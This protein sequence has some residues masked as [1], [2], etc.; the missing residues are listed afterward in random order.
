MK[1]YFLLLIVFLLC[2]CED[3]RELN[4]MAITTAMTIDYNDEKK[5]FEVTAQI[6]DIK[7]SKDTSSNEKK[8]TTFSSGSSS[9]QEAIRKITLESS[10]NLYTPQLHLLIVS[11]NIINNHLN[12]TLDF[13]MR[14]PDKLHLHQC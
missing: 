2:G 1:K 14:N 10:R 7:K 4:K 9:I 13:F 3:Y 5:E 12:E 6:I 11:K 8:F